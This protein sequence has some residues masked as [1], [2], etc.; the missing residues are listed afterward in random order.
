MKL[1]NTFYHLFNFM[2]IVAL[3]L[4]VFNGCTELAQSQGTQ[5]PDPQP[6]L[7]IVTFTVTPLTAQPEQGVTFTWSLKNGLQPVSCTLDVEGDRTVEYNLS[8][9]Q[10]TLSQSHSYKRAGH[11][12]AVLTVSDGS[13]LTKTAVV[14]TLITAPSET[15]TILA[16][17][18][19]ACDPASEH[20]NGGLGTEKRCRQKYV[21]DL[22][23]QLKPDAVLTLGDSQYEENTLEQFLASYDLSWG[24]YKAL[25]YPVAGNHEYL[26]RNAA[27]YYSYFGAVAGDPNKG[28]YSYD[29][30]AWHIIALN[31]NCDKV[32]GCSAPSPQGQWL[33]A[34]LA[35]HP[36]QCTLAYWHHPRFSS[37]HH[38]NNAE[39]TDFWTILQQ[40]GAELILTGHDHNYERFAAQ[41]ARGNAVPNGI[42][43]FVVGTGGKGI[44][45]LE[46]LQ[47]NSA[48][49]SSEVY[50]AL[51]LT[52]EPSSY[53]WNFRVENQTETPFSDSG[54]AAC[55]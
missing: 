42:V 51:E 30:G 38:G 15:V 34:D 5:N 46:T 19:I 16:A 4:F 39:Y 24:K 9:C 40:A 33:K 48:A 49:R 47:P 27:D 32:D 12:Q 52:L 43:Q 8:D 13:N 35:A 55:H 10:T 45:P 50:G 28:Y 6:S 17:G 21:A 1:S 29:L 31:S 18:D 25:T 7:D 3:S 36:N 11:Y 37:G 41:D 2:F 22:I 26:T 44:R 53:S 14:A 20:F 54:Q 23:G